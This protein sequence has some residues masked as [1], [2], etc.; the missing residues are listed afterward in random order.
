MMLP[1]RK[2]ASCSYQPGNLAASNLS[3]FIFSQVLLNTFT[4]CKA[5]YLQPGFR[6]SP[7]LMDSTPL[8]ELAETSCFSILSHF[9]SAPSLLPQGHPA[10]AQSAKPM[11]SNTKQQFSKLCPNCWM[12]MFVPKPTSC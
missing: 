6:D 10:A 7:E 2:T 11:E 9:P 4:L 1:P 3:N 12:L 5:W 8:S